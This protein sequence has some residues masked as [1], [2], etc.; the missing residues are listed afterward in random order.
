[1]TSSIGDSIHLSLFGES[2]GP[3]IGVVIDGLAAGI[4]LDLDQLQAQMEKRRAKGRLSTAR[5]EGDQVE[6][7]SGFFQ[8][9]TT[10]SPLC[11]LIRNQQQH[12]RDYEATKTLLR[13]S[14]ADFTAF[15]KY[16]GFQDYRGGGHFSGRITA[17]LVAAGAVMLQILAAKGIRVGTHIARCAGVDDRPF[18]SGEP[19]LTQAIAAL[20][21]APFPVLDRE[22]GDAMAAAIEAA[23]LEGD[24][25]GGVLETAV[26]GLPTGVGEPFF[27]S[28]ESV[29]AS[30]LFSVPAV[31]GVEFG[32]GFAMS[33]LRGSQA[34]D[35]FQM[36]GGRIRTATNH[37]GGI[38]GGITNGMPL[39]VRTAVKPTPS[40]YKP[41][42]TVD[43][44][45]RENATLVIQGRHDP[46]IIHR[47]RVVVDSV[48]AFGLC[49][50]CCRRFG[51]L[52][53]L[54]G[55]PQAFDRGPDLGV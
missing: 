19:Q 40:I 18:P 12:S 46:A 49:D 45:R 50:L 38:N 55:F 36:D 2:H 27:H 24:S 7:Q 52:W 21:Q 31:K 32:L 29:L 4:P 9:H 42:Q 47:A 51:T 39:L 25:V 44:A 48:V 5:Q 6:I 1:M 41:Q 23:R 17:P 34:N 54:E 10:G 33:D 53:Q 15:E 3:A 16:G 11:L 26:T 37:N 43:Y 30:L 22:Q 8:G 28:V 35:P 20:D 13:P 14:H